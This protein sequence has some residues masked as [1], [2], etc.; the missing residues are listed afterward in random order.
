MA[1]DHG[2]TEDEDKPSESTDFLPGSS[3][4]G[5]IHSVV[6]WGKQAIELSC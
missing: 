1:N 3:S 4:T 2:P 5:S 6:C